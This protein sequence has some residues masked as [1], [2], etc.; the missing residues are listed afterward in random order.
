LTTRPWPRDGKDLP[1]WGAIGLAWRISLK[2]T[3]D[4]ELAG[5]T[6][7]QQLWFVLRASICVAKIFPLTV[8]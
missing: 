4:R 5:T 2:V 8:A 7:S 3:L 6:A 1:V